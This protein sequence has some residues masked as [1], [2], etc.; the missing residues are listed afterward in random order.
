MVCA[1]RLLEKPG[2]KSPILVEGL[3][4]IGLVAN[5]AVAHLIQK[6]DAKLFGE[7]RSH[8]FQD[9]AMTDGKGSFSLP[10]NQLYYYK[11]KEEAGERDLI[12][13][14]GNTQAL[15]TRGQ[16]E[17]CGCVIDV[18]ESLGCQYIIT[19]GGYRPGRNVTEPKLYYA[20]SD[21]ET[22]Q[23]ATNLGA[24][25]LG[26]QIFGVAG[27][28]VGLCGL[29]GIKS[30]CLLAETPGTYP[31]KEA[32][33]EVLKAISGLL[34]LKLDLSDLTEAVEYVNVLSPFDFGALAKTKKPKKEPTPEWFI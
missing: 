33:R 11:G 29:R 2:L 26:G 20:A 16:Y 18:A 9:I 1:V 25:I 17:L 5:I 3:P 19:L 31:D 6:L 28:L 27:L 24:E 30:F 34:G 23:T 15:T 4:G 7:I 10:T 8:A 14:Y 21:T 13:L 22:A 32:A 12:L